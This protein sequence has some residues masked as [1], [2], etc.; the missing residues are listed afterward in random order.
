[1]MTIKPPTGFWN[2]RP[3]IVKF[4]RKPKIN[5]GDGRMQD[6]KFQKDQNRKKRM[7]S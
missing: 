1:M 2:V 7:F 3:L 5:L 6:C 4:S